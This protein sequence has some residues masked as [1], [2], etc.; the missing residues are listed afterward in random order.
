MLHSGD[1]ARFVGPMFRGNLVRGRHC[2]G[3][4]HERAITIHFDDLGTKAA[5][6]TGLKFNRDKC[7]M[8]ALG[9]WRQDP[10]DTPD[11][12]LRRAVHGKYLR[13]RI[14]ANGGLGSGSRTA[15]WQRELYVA[16]SGNLLG[17][18]ACMVIWA[19]RADDAVTMSKCV[20]GLH[21]AALTI[22][23]LA[24]LGAFR[25]RGLR[26]FLK[27]R[28]PYVDGNYERTRPGR[29]SQSIGPKGS[30]AD[31][32]ILGRL[33]G[34]TEE[35]A[36]PCLMRPPGDPMR[37]VTLFDGT[38]EPKFARTNRV[39][40]PRLHWAIERLLPRGQDGGVGRPDA[41]REGAT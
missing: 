25:M 19:L 37:Q 31:T 32:T 30:C 4:R 22:G 17:N 27:M 12:H 14:Y 2:N 13:C 8:L 7:E 26:Q 11:G 23:Q 29:G 39:G 33:H 24:R 38:G 9:K 40:R 20:Y 36:R 16:A 5:R 41:L 21:I 1:P 35:L 10:F 15:H 6:T 18:A 28:H 34:T 3:S